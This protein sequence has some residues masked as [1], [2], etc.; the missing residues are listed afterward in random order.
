MPFSLTGGLRQVGEEHLEANG[1]PLHALMK[2]GQSL[3]VADVT[4]DLI[5]RDQLVS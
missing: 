2:V 1:E 4:Q 3:Q 5:L